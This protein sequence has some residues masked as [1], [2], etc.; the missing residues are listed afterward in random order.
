MTELNSLPFGTPDLDPQP[1]VVSGPPQRVRCYV[2][3]CQELLRPP[4]RG[5][6]GDVCR[7]HGI[8]CHYSTRGATYSYAEVRRN[9][10][11][12][13]D[14][15]ATRIVG[16]PH[17]FETSRLGYENSE[18]A[19]TW[20]VFRTLQ[21]YRLLHVVAR[22]IT[23]LDVDTEPRLDLW[24][25]SISDA[26]FQPWDLLLAARA[27][28]ESN[29][30]V[31]R[32]PTEPDIALYLP[33]YYL[34]LIETK[35]TSPNPFYT[36]GPRRDAQ[37]LT[38]QEL[39]DI[40]QDPVLHM[41]DVEYARQADRVYYQLWRNMVFTEWMALADGSGTSAYHANLTR[42]AAQGEESCR[43]FAASLQPRFK[44]RFTQ[45]TW[46]TIHA[47]TASDRLDLRLLRRY[48][49]TKTAALVPAFRV[50]KRA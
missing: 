17:K 9:I 4:A 42:A 40:Y 28:F 44:D 39:L 12:A 14:L 15:F 11:V 1:H 37:S 29:L 32:P 35:F 20:N 10:I 45:L 18:D 43:D 31:E 38:K 25:L 13:A 50:E 19:L 7:I 48:L 33:G 47:L 8:R 6:R 3:G 2:R 16:N 27:R 41:L 24:G 21:E 34:I 22:W 46:E 36:D 30:P 26:T 23:G 5:C 49:D